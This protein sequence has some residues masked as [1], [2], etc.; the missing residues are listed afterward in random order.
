M[1]FSDL[2]CTETARRKFET[3]LS[4]DVELM[5]CVIWL[6][7]FSSSGIGGAAGATPFSESLN[8]MV[9]EIG[10][11]LVRSMGLPGPDGGRWYCEGFRN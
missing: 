3:N 7:C 2:Q 10:S 6:N 11:P 8:D 1:K 9:S 5:S 4:E